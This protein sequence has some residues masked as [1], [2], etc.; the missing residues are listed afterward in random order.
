MGLSMCGCFGGELV[1]R[2]WNNTSYVILMC[3]KMFRQPIEIQKSGKI[4]SRLTSRDAHKSKI[5]T[6][7]LLRKAGARV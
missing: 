2:A 3:P 7:L 4:L 1:V 5:N 6:T